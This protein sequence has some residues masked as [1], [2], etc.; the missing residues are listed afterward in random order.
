MPPDPSPDAGREAVHY[1]PEQDKIVRRFEAYRAANKWSAAKAAQQIRCAP[2]TYNQLINKRYPGRFA[3]FITAMG[4]VLARAERRDNAIKNPPYAVTANAETIEG[5]CQHCLDQ[6]DM[7]LVQ[8]PT[9]SCKTSA[10]V[11]Y[12]TAHVADVILITAH[13]RF[14]GV[15]LLRKLAD[16][17]RLDW[18]GKSF[19]VLFDRVVV[20]LANRG[21]PLIIVDDVDNFGAEAL[22]T[23]RQ[24]HDQAEC[25]VLLL[26]TATFLEKIRRRKNGLDLQAL[27]RLGCV[28]ALHGIGRDDAAKLSDF[29]KLPAAA[30]SMAWQL[31]GGDARLLVKGCKAALVAARAYGEPVSASHVETGFEKLKAVRSTA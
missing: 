26:G 14:N 10:A 18:T 13:P 27:G 8:G 19:D 7:A 20:H 12:A 9:G 21:Q 16:H 11:A 15:A 1:T 29:F 25:P 23:I 4:N 22:H 6:L 28:E 2:S 24:I 31:C 5:V 3:A 17:E 30:S